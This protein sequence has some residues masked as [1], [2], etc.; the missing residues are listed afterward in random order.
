MSQFGFNKIEVLKSTD[1]EALQLLQK[2]S[3]NVQPLMTKYKWSVPLLKESN[4]EDSSVLGMNV[5][6]GE[7]ILIRLRQVNST[8]FYP[9]EHLLGTLCH[10]LAHNTHGPHNDAFYKFLDELQTQLENMPSGGLSGFDT[11]GNKLGGD[12]ILRSKINKNNFSNSAASNAANA[13]EYRAKQHQFFF[14]IGGVKLGGTNATKTKNS[15]NTNSTK[16]PAQMAAEA[17][18][19][20]NNS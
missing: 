8:T 20:R 10:E 9:Y 6:G 13:A 14:P 4:F 2:L 3:R 7:S 15:D 5:N 12:S 19:K 18:L 17:A 1:K 11:C 16:T